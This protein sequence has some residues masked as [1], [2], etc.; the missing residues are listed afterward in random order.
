MS[1]E[2]AGYPRFKRLI[3]A[4][5]LYV[6]F[7]P[8]EDERALAEEAADSHEIGITPDD[9]EARLDVDFSVLGDDEK[10]AAA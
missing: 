8:S 10:A 7:T 5:E 9:Y 4:R 3:T 2:R 6:F 1:I